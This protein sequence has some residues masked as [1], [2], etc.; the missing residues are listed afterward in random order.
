MVDVDVDAGEVTLAVNAL[1][2]KREMNG[3]DTGGGN[4][5]SANHMS[6]QSSSR[7]QC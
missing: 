1:G 2:L 5:V 4:L 7:E 6:R 3:R